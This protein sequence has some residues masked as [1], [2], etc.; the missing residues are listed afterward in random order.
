M[1]LLEKVTDEKTA[2]PV[3]QEVFAAMRQAVGD[4]PEPLKMLAVSPGLLQVQ[5]AMIGYY[6]GHAALSPELLTCIRFVAGS[7]FENIACVRFNAGLLK[8]Q[9]MTEE[10]LEELKVKPLAAPLEDKD[11]L[12]LSFVAKAVTGVEAT[13]EAMGKLRDVGFQDSDILDAVNHGFAMYAPGKMLKFFGLS[14]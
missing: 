4:V 12:M 11:R 6:G 8:R 2:S 3:V 5:A 1:A 7:H 10:E 13:A 14:S 9:G